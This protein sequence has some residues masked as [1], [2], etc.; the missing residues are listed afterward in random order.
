[1]LEEVKKLR[2]ESLI[3]AIDRVVTL[4]ASALAITVTFKSTL[5]IDG[6]INRLILIASWAGFAVAVL[7][8]T[9]CRF[10][11]F[12]FYSEWALSFHLKRD[13]KAPPFWMPFCTAVAVIGFV[14]G[15]CCLVAA[16]AFN[17]LD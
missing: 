12:R 15:I 17:L 10:L 11:L 13:F 2:N 6:D 4:S 1:M 16:A 8:G 9:L 14:D 3:T 7:F 5:A